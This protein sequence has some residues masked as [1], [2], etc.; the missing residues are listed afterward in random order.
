MSIIH[1]SNNESWTAHAPGIL[2]NSL[3]EDIYIYKINE[4]N[5]IGNV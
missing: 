1:S 4:I 3:K 2:F 5:N